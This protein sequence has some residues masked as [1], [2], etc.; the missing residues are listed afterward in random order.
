MLSLDKVHNMNSIDIYSSLFNS[1]KKIYNNYYF[2]MIDEEQ[3]KE[4]ALL[5]I[6][7]SHNKYNSKISYEDYLTHRLIQKSLLKVKEVLNDNDT[8]IKLINKYINL[9]FKEKKEYNS[10][11]Y[12]INRLN[13]FFNTYDYYPSYDTVSELF[14]NNKKFSMAVKVAFE[15]NKNAIVNGRVDEIYSSPFIISLME[16]YADKNNIELKEKPID[17]N[18]AY[19]STDLYNTYIKEIAAYPL[20]NP[21]EEKELGS[22]LKYGD[23]ELPDELVGMTDQYSTFDDHVN[24]I[25]KDD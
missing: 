1:L 11:I 16:M 12:S 2:F 14:N 25:K 21:V 5:E 24:I 20:L 7:R 19:I 15:Q 3:F 9:V 4:V 6:E 10:V 13:K 18:E 23:K 8:G 17:F 22:I